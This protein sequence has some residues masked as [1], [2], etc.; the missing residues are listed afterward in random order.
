MNLYCV[1]IDVDLVNLVSLTCQE[2]YSCNNNLTR[3][4]PVGNVASFTSKLNVNYNDSWWWM[5][6]HFGGE[7][8]TFT[9]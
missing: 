6:K 3:H 8:K 2:S 7:V 5:N 9:A 1:E 4:V